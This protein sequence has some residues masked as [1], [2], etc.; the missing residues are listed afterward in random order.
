M[1]FVETGLPA[2]RQPFSWASR[3]G[4]LL[5]TA[6]GPVDGK[7]G[8]AGSGVEEQA[9]LTFR[10]LA[11]ACAAAGAT[12]G[13]VAQVLIYL[14]EAEHMLAVDAVYREHFVAPYP[15]RSSVVVKDFV[16]PEML[17]E[18]VAYVDLPS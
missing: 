4:N 18:I 12:L 7:G 3:A 13:D 10:N 11:T 2:M 15:N 14:K 5:F 16:H 17:I 6:H 9:R 8:I 1:Q